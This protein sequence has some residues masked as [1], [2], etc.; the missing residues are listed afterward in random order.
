MRSYLSYSQL[1]L[2]L[3]CPLKYRFRYID[4]IR[5]EG[6]SSALLFGKTIHQVLARFYTD[7]MEGKPFSLTAFLGSFAEMWREACEGQRVVYGKEEN[8]N[9]LLTRGQELLRVFVRGRLPTLRVIAVEVPFEFK[10][11]NPETGEEFPVPI[12]GIIDLIEEDEQGTLWV[13]DHKTSS[14]AFSDHDLDADLQLMIYAAAVEQLDMVEGRQKRYRFD[15]LTKTKQPKFL[16]YRLYKDGKDRQKLYR[17]VTEIWK[18][19]EAGAFYPRYSMH[20][21]GCPWEE[22]CREW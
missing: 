2:Y 20:Y 14:R 13:V 4:E 21:A 3:E 22:E 7:A 8:F 10:L 15:V 18:A 11:E 9:S 16:Q 12:K 17:L 5:T 6:V 19:I 1:A